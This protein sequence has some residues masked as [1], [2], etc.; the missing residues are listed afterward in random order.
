MEEQRS[1][2]LR[3]PEEDVDKI[4]EILSKNE[5][6]GLRFNFEP[7][8]R[9]GSVWVFDKINGMPVDGLTYVA[10]VLDLPRHVESYEFN[11]EE[12]GIKFYNKKD[13]VSQ[14]II[15]RRMESP[16]IMNG[17]DTV[18]NNAQSPLP[19]ESFI[20]RHGITP[21]TMNIVPK[22]TT[23]DD[24]KK[25]MSEIHEME[26]AMLYSITGTDVKEN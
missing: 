5:N 6:F 8:S 20:Y 1:A 16:C 10:E 26:K 23:H 2:V 22:S 15:M 18:V 24:I 12:P 17:P 14:I 13:D 19:D 4:D 7:G 25:S 21:P 11:S 9:I 3:F